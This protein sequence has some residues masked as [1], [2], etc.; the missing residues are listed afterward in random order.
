MI[1]DLGL[2]DYEE[3]YSIQ[4]EFVNRRKFGEIDDSIILAEHPSVFTIGRTGVIVNLIVEEDILNKKGIKILRVDRGGDITFHG[5]G[6]LVCY[7]ILD[8]SHRGRDLH[9]YLRDLE[10]AVIGFLKEYS[11]SSER[12]EGRTGVWVSGEKIASIG[13]AASNWITYHG[14][15]ININ[16]D[17]GFFSMINPCGMKGIR[18]VSLEHILGR[19][20]AMDEVK[21]KILPYL[22]EV[23]GI[24]DHEAKFRKYA[25]LA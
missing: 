8:L 14:V 9:K 19:E 5:P 21:A 23:F 25:L 15:S 18:A 11:V 10:E 17:T 4:K 3:C 16:V 24:E 22:K 12:L 2:I 1:I 20:I 13:V 7:P 6:Q